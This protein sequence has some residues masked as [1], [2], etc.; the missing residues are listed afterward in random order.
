MS[1]YDVATVNQELNMIV[2]STLFAFG[3]SRGMWDA[4]ANQN[5]SFDEEERLDHL[6][7]IE[8]SK[9]HR[10]TTRRSLA[11]QYAG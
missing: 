7:N 2:R 10:S 11:S 8:Y 9:Y 6:E 4:M 5:S 3:M 1:N